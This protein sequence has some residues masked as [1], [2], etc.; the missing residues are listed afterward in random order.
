MLM[1]VYNFLRR[2]Q[3][4]SVSLGVIILAVTMTQLSS[5]IVLHRIGI[6]A[7]NSAAAKY[8][9]S[10]AQSLVNE[11]WGDDLGSANCANNGPQIQPE[12]AA[13]SPIVSISGGGQGPPGP[14]GPKGDAGDTGPRGPP[15]EQGPPG[16]DK[17]LQVRTVLGGSEEVQPGTTGQAS[18]Q[19]AADEFVTGG[20][21]SKDFNEVNPGVRNLGDPLAAPDRWVFLYDNPGPHPVTIEAI[22]ECAKLVDAL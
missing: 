17:E 13:S 22:A 2:N 5:M 18:A 11:C 12:G 1:K 20:G 8:S 4:L 9:N 19:C 14:Q 3:G 6:T 15:G 21:A 16:P 7:P 10:Q